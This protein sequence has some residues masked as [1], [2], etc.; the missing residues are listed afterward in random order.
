MDALAPSAGIGSFVTLIV[1]MFYNHRSP[2]A[3]IER[4]PYAIATQGGVFTPWESEGSGSYTFTSTTPTV[5]VADEGSDAQ[6][7]QDGDDADTRRECTPFDGRMQYTNGVCSH[8]ALSRVLTVDT[9][10]LALQR[11]L[12]CGRVWSESQCILSGEIGLSIPAAF[13]YS[14]TKG[15]RMVAAP[16]L[17]SSPPSAPT[18]G[19][20]DDDDAR[21]AGDDLYVR[22]N[23]RQTA[24]RSAGSYVVRM[25]RSIDI[26]F[27]L[28]ASRRVANERLS[29]SDA[30]CVQ[31]LRMA[32]SD[33]CWNALD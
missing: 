4:T 6:R 18:R 1:T 7:Q 33:D 26:E 32:F 19:K 29:G 2:D 11:A 9:H 3:P 25:R 10:D 14:P 5:G 28:G 13:L 8:F 31:L 30:Y 27:T 23:Y 16:R 17:V 22:V 24:N 21:G 12:R 15:M 20:D